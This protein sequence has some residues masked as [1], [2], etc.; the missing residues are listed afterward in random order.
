VLAYPLWEYCYK[1]SPVPILPVPFGS[2]AKPTLMSMWFCDCCYNPILVTVWWADLL[3]ELLQTYHSVC[4][5]ACPICYCYKHILVLSCPILLV[6]QTYPSVCLPSL[7]VLLQTTD[8]SGSTSLLPCLCIVLPICYY[9]YNPIPVSVCW[10][11]LSA[12]IATNL[13]QCWPALSGSIA[14]N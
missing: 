10:A 11:A 7:E 5:L 13:P 1:A 3:V 6:L 12:I 4:V 8:L 14:T 2:I 9:C